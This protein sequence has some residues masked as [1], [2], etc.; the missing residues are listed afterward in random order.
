MML[1]VGFAVHC[2]QQPRLVNCFSER[3]GILASSALLVLVRREKKSATHYCT[4]A[5]LR[6]GREEKKRGL[7]QTISTSQKKEREKKVRNTLPVHKNNDGQQHTAIVLVSKSNDGQQTRHYREY[8]VLQ[9]T[10]KTLHRVQST[11]Q[12]E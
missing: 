3:E 7:K 8:R 10:N 1:A 12:Q 11:S 4:S 2:L 6:G 9:S 5:S